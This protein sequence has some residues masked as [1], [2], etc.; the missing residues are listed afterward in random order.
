MWGP[1]GRHFFFRATWSIVVAVE[2]TGRTRLAFRPTTS[3]FLASPRGAYVQGRCF[4]YF[5]T[6]ED[7]TGYVLWGAPG[8]SDIDD[9]TTLIGS[10]LARLPPHPSIVDARALEGAPPHLFDR[11]AAFIRDN[12]DALQRSATR[13][14]MV[15]GQGIAG[16][17]VGGFFDVV[18]PPYPVKAFDVLADAL[19]WLGVEEAGA[20]AEELEGLREAASSVPPLIRQLRTVVD[21]ALPHPDEAAVA[22]SLGLSSRT[23][24]RRVCAGGP[25]FG[26]RVAQVRG[27]RARTLLESTDDPLT[28]IAFD[29]GCPSLSSFSTL[30]RKVTGETPSAIR[31]K[32]RGGH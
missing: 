3:A 27:A 7:L 18:T 4:F 23:M 28:R 9:L 11:L 32:R 24:Q 16:A 6:S 13:L 26:G 22:R 31:A 14:A 15:R 21:D 25:T 10:S 1:R 29:V 2:R 5:Q 17:V 19:E 20:F 12:R 30:G 8:S